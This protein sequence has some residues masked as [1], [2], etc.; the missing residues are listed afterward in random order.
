MNRLRLLKNILSHI[1]KI[2]DF[3]H[4]CEHFN[5]LP[6]PGIFANYFLSFPQKNLLLEKSEKTFQLLNNEID[7]NTNFTNLGFIRIDIR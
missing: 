1:Y 3:S 2:S 5:F 7:Q 4:G 6:K